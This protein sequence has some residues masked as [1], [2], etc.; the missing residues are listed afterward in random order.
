MTVCLFVLMRKDLASM[1]P[2]K[3]CAQAAHAA[4]QCVALIDR[5]NITHISLHEEWIAQTEHGFG[6]TIVLGVNERQMRDKIGLALDL[7]LHAGIVHDPSYPIRD[8]EITHAIPLDTCGYV[9]ALKEQVSKLFCDLEL[10]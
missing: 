6:T 8:G 3:A 9:L 7:G 10:L 1:V 5:S 2:G 4:N